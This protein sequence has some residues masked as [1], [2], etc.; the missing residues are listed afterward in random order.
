M[1][2]NL[3]SMYTDMYAEETETEEVIVE[4][5]VDRFALNDYTKIVYE[6]KSGHGDDRG[7]FE[8]GSG[9]NYK[10]PQSGFLPKFE[11]T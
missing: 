5:K 2:K 1:R 7:G 4:E 6:G 11:P 9:D 8:G 3:Q 10:A